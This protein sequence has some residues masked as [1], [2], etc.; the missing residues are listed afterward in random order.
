MT[1]PIASVPPVELLELF[2][3]ARS[4]GDLA[5]AEQ[6]GERIVTALPDHA[7]TLSFLSC[8]ARL[9]GDGAGAC[10]WAGQGVRHHPQSAQLRFDL[11]AALSASGRPG[12]ARNELSTALR[13]QP[14]SVP[15]QLWLGSAEAQVGNADAA[16]GLRVRA[17]GEAERQGY[18]RH[19]ERLA[20]DTHQQ[21]LE[22]NAATQ[23]ERARIVTS[24]LQEL[25]SRCGRGELRRIHRAFEQFFSANP[26]PPPHPLQRP[27]F[28]FVPGLPDLPWFER[29]QFPFLSAIEDKTDQ[30]RAEMLA[31]LT[32]ETELR[33]YV[34]MPDDA[35][36]AL[37]MGELNRSLK[38]SAYHFHRHGERIEEHCRRC[39][40]T[41]AALDALPLHR[42]PDHGPEAM[43][44][45]LR[46][47]AHITPHTGVINGRLTVHL[48]LLVPSDCG[49]LAVARESRP[50][51][52][53][54]CLVF[55]DSFV[56]EAWN[57]SE[58]T[59][60]VLIFDLW[61]PYLSAIEQEAMAAVIH[62]L[63]AFNRRY[64][65]L[66]TTLES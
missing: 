36:G 31:V 2:A 10:R 45:V 42:V 21:L 66:D 15:A 34:D 33:P 16:L 17:L 32:E 27:T 47:G 48:P 58:H 64:G 24:I 59:R 22:A 39:P 19:P 30:I 23:Q 46:P 56:H 52:E 53:G 3:T 41:A 37:F 40:V 55:D 14:G 61:N 57:A 63:G 13:L 25:R 49:A 50:W 26:Q 20:A 44:S 62:A 5:Q 1:T 51:H 54:Q 11:G 65:L 28:L 35:P 43:Y 60:V 9:R 18:L 38:W 29:E 6:L 8:Q 4:R 7:A 12:E